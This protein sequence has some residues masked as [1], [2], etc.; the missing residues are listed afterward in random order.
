MSSFAIFSVATPANSVG[1]ARSPY[2]TNHRDFIQYVPN[3]LPANWKLY[4]SDK[5]DADDVGLI[6]AHLFNAT[7]ISNDFDIR[8]QLI[9]GIKTRIDNATKPQHSCRSY[10][11]EVASLV[12]G[13][14]ITSC[15]IKP[16]LRPVNVLISGEGMTFPENGW[17]DLT[18]MRASAVLSVNPRKVGYPVEFGALGAGGVSAA[19]WDMNRQFHGPNANFCSV[20]DET[21]ATFIKAIPQL[22]VAAASF[23]G[24]I[25]RLLPK[26]SC[27]YDQVK[28]TLNDKPVE[29]SVQ[30]STVRLGNNAWS[31]G[32][33]EQTLTASYI[34]EKPGDSP[35]DFTDPVFYFSSSS[36]STNLY[37][38]YARNRQILRFFAA[39]GGNSMIACGFLNESG[40]SILPAP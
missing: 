21:P 33:D 29:F 2:L 1:G 34:N 11:P 28:G 22:E 12:A 40:K 24:N 32:G 17:V 16:N 6:Q 14:Y 4:R 3:A 31:L 8:P 5:T 38:E 36:G 37:L 9:S 39:E 13:R 20:E 27:V 25:Y 15:G 35:S 23:L 26:G 19:F 18:D 10:V 7:Y 30:G